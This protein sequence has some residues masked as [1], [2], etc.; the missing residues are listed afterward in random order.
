MKHVKILLAVATIVILGLVSCSKG[1]TGP[2][3][4]VGP[5][6]PDS[7]YVFTMD[8]PDRNSGRYKCFCRHDYRSVFDKGNIR[9]WHY[10]ILC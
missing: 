1:D 7:V 3:G 2:A 6:G 4:P 10:S 5:A 9:Q 8:K